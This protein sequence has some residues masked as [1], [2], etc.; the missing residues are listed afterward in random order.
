MNVMERDIWAIWKSRNK[1]S[2]NNQDVSQAEMREALKGQISNMV[3]KSWNAMQFLIDSKKQTRRQALW[4]LW[5]HRHFVKLD[6]RSNLTF[7]FC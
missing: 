2:I 3:R 1:N 6:H 4:V 5:A 7:D